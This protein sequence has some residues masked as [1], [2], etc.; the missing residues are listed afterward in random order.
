M[1][2]AQQAPHVPQYQPTHCSFAPD[3]SAKV[4]VALRRSETP[5]ALTLPQLVPTHPRL[6][7]RQPTRHPPPSTLRAP[8]PA[9]VQPPASRSGPAER[10]RTPSRPDRA[11]PPRPRHPDAPPTRR[12]PLRSTPPPPHRRA[13]PA[14]AHRQSPLGAISRSHLPPL[15]TSRRGTTRPRTSAILPLLSQDLAQANQAP[16]NVRL[17][18]AQRQP[19]RLGDPLVR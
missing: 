13:T 7:A 10:P 16:P 8:D 14:A 19:R 18:G 17:D 4:R 3:R 9:Q 1:G 11:P 15:I 2:D 12:S 6:L 5:S